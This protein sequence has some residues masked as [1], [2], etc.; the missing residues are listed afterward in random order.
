M[1]TRFISHFWKGF[2]Q[3]WGKRLNFSTTYH[4]QT[5]GQSKRK[6]RTLEDML[7]EC[8]LEWTGDRDK[9]FYLVEFAYNNSWHASIG[10]ELVR[11]TNEK[12]EKVKESLKE[13]QPRQKSYADQHQ[14]FGGFKSDDYVFLKVSPCKGVKRFGIKGK[15]S[16]RGY[17][18]HPLQVVQYPLH[19]IR[20]DLSCEEEAEAILAREERVLSKNIIPFV[21]V[22]WKNHSERGYMGL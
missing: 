18:Y 19:K 3:A 8:A 20:E 1:D 11:I 14:K 15:L 16:P 5:D 13:A 17:K 6:I 2:Q 22:L 12:V 9:Y 4:P 21:K 10:P 7:R